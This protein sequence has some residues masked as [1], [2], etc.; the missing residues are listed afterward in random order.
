MLHGFIF[1]TNLYLSKQRSISYAFEKQRTE[2]LTICSFYHAKAKTDLM[3][4]ADFA[5]EDGTAVVIRQNQI[6]EGTKV[7]ITISPWRV[8]VYCKG[9]EMP[10][11]DILQLGE[12]TYSGFGT[13]IAKELEAM[14]PDATVSIK[15]ELIVADARIWIGDESMHVNEEIFATSVTYAH[16]G[17]ILSSDGFN[18]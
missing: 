14:H 17:V 2:F 13:H 4:D 12:D 1:G 10:V 9:G 6:V 8:T 3:L 11:L 18:Y 7:S 15:G 16:Q 5:L